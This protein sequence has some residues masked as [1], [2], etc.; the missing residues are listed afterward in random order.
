MLVRNS[1][2]CGRVQSKLYRLLWYVFPNL[3]LLIGEGFDLSKIYKPCIF[4]HSQVHRG[5]CLLHWKN[6]TSNACKMIQK[7]LDMDPLCEV[8]QSSLDI[9]SV[10]SVIFSAYLTSTETTLCSIFSSSP[11]RFSVLWRCSDTISMQLWICLR[12]RLAWPN[13]KC[14]LSI[15]TACNSA[16]LPSLASPSDLAAFFLPILPWH[17]RHYLSILY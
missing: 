14:S 10:S 3:Q 5:L 6:D 13:S 1:R 16:L 8:P 11:T 15:S 12:R 7:A 17:R 4:Y 9:V 2:R